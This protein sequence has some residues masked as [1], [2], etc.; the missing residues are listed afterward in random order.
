M[1]LA[2]WFAMAALVAAA[3]PVLI[4][5]LNRRRFRVV[6]WAAMDF[7]R[8]AVR[9][10]RRI[11]RLRDLLLLALRTAC[12]LLFGLALARPYLSRATAAISPDQ[13]VHGV[14]LV[15]NSLSMSYQELD[16]T[17][18]D[19][20]KHKAR[21]WIERQPSGSRFSI[22]PLCGATS[23]LNLDPLPTRDDAL[24][25]L[26]AIQTVDRAATPGGAVQ[27]AQEAC[28]RGAELPAKQIVL[29]GDAQVTGRPP[30]ALGPQL[31]RLPVP[32]QTIRVAAE[33][34]E[35]AW[36]ERFELQDQIADVATPAVFL[37]T[38][39]YQGPQPRR[40][41]QVTLAIDGTTVASTT[42]DLVPGQAREIRFPP[43]R[44]SVAP[45]PG[46]AVLVKAAVAIAPDRLPT[47]DHRYRIVPVV[48]GLPVVFVD[49]YGQGEDPRR[50]RYG[51]TYH[52]R[53]LLAPHTGG[54]DAAG[55]LIR[56]RH[57]TADA[58]DR[59][60][61]ADARLVVVAGLSNPRPLVEPLRQYVLQGGPLLLVAGG[62]FDPVTWNEL[63]WLEGLGILPAPLKPEFVGRLADEPSDKLQTFQIDFHS[64]VHDWFLLEQVSSEELEDL[65]GLPYFFKAAA[66]EP[67]DRWLDVMLRRVGRQ[68]ESTR[69]RL[70]EI[71]AELAKLP[72]ADTSGRR[73]QLQRDRAAVEPNWL[74][75][76]MPPS[77]VDAA[78][79]PAEELA[80][81]SRPRVVAAL[82]NG[83]PLLV[84]RRIGAGRVL[85][86][87]SGLSSNWSTLA[88]TN[89]MLLLDRI[90]RDL[91]QATF[92]R[93]NLDTNEPISM[94][95]SAADRSARFVL[96]G[97][98]G[99]PQVLAADAVGADRYAVT[100]ANPARRGHYQ[101]AAFAPAAGGRESPLW[102]VPLAVNG[103]AEESDL[104]GPEPASGKS[105]AAEGL[106]VADRSEVAQEASAAG[107]NLWRW[108]MLAA[109][110]CLLLELGLLAAPMLGREARS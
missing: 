8:Q 78:P 22:L 4:H 59:A 34:A 29:I 45:E 31:A 15:D 82:T 26:A 39:R 99:R 52:L 6:E 105:D 83:T 81:R 43:Y 7:L 97:P 35:N 106:W 46:R 18:L 104:R 5:L 12:V 17:L 50:N 16:R 71:D 86:F 56:V 92:P 90:C 88:L 10:S 109:L 9:R 100:A 63:A 76:R 33:M 64:L 91:L 68:I 66:L 87:S 41:V 102:E 65:Y 98:E 14:V 36:V 44:F 53:R 93:R 108:F 21:Q 24:E 96:T 77:T 60:L 3:G 110:V 37:A 47:D 40:D 101:L 57:V 42:V 85:W 54:D 84:E 20:A 1:F 11:L 80:E 51:E 95:V 58:V 32:V 89:T 19:V 67:S 74:L 70:A 13:P 94:P 28:R 103:P 49:Q 27:L 79:L 30:E 72:P 73:E 2:P 62:Q 61:L 75:W 38:V 69:S 23:G 48:A 107:Q 25:A 55:Q